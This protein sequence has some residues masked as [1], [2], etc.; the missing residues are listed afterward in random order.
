M[1]ARAARRVFDGPLRSAGRQAFAFEG[2]RAFSVSNAPLVADEEQ[3]PVVATEAPTKP[4][5]LLE[6]LLWPFTREASVAPK[7]FNR[8]LVVPGSSLVQI[9]I[10]R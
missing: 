7:G 6:K 9:S 3:S 5:S 1:L 4:R 10:G 2:L 8:W